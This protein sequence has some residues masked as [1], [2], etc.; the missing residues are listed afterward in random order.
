MS[1]DLQIKKDNDVLVLNEN[2]DI[3]TTNEEENEVLVLPEENEVLPVSNDNAA[4]KTPL[5]QDRD[6]ARF[7][8]RIGNSI[9]YNGDQTINA[10]PKYN[11]YDLHIEL[12]F[13]TTLLNLI[14]PT[15][16]SISYPAG[17]YLASETE[18]QPVVSEMID[19][20]ERRLS[21]DTHMVLYTIDVADAITYHAGGPFLYINW[22]VDLSSISSTQRAGFANRNYSLSVSWKESSVE[23]PQLV[24][25][26][27]AIGSAKAY[28]LYRDISNT[29]EAWNLDG[30]L[31]TD[32]NPSI[33]YKG[34]IIT[35]DP[36]LGAMVEGQR[37]KISYVEGAQYYTFA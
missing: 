32:T 2:N 25:S 10:Q 4:W 33:N 22:T 35:S 18:H 29:N 34:H 21:G 14:T 6:T 1:N 3:I 37:Y 13:D 5:L 11:Q 7:T 26:N 23:R 17:S 19:I 20:V 24:A 28:R 12:Y 8:S 15:S 27:I 16:A 9:F 31:A 30:Y 36:I